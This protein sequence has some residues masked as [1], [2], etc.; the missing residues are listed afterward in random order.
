LYLVT[1]YNDIYV[2]EHSETPQIVEKSWDLEDLLRGFLAG[3]V[4]FAPSPF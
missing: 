2:L 1:T 4:G 3:G